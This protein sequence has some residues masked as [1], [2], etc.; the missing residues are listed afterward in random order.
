MDY[1]F[2]NVK[3]EVKSNLVETKKIRVMKVR[4]IEVQL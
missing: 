1:V 3:A 2:H 4:F